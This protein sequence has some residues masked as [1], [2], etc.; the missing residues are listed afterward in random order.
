MLDF[1]KLFNKKI[2]TIVIIMCLLAYSIMGLFNFAEAASTYNQ[3][4]KS[5]IEAF[6]EDYQSYLKEIQNYHPNW[7]FDAY[8]TGIDWNELVANETDHGHNRVINSADPLWKCSC[9]NVATGYACASAGI[10]K[11]YMDPR[12]FLSNDVKIFQFL[13]ISYNEKIHNVGR[14]IKCN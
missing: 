11:Y 4:V 7:T 2:V 14:N 12:N 10:I 9:G 3:Y 1:I 8:Y 5:G 6:P 13:E